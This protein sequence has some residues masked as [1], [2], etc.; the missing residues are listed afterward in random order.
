M[1]D[2]SAG[3]RN[4]Q[5]I[6]GEGSVWQVSYWSLQTGECHWEKFESVYEAAERAAELNGGTSC[7]LRRRMRSL[8][9]GFLAWSRAAPPRKRR[10]GSG[11]R[12]HWNLSPQQYDFNAIHRTFFPSPIFTQRRAWY[13]ALKFFGGE[14]A[15]CRETGASSHIESFLGNNI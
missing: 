8:L 13:Q 9:R 6:L 15:V 1:S 14:R 12:D 7:A 11:G 3:I 4:L 5:I 2:A 10:S